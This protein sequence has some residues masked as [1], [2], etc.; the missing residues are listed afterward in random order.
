[1]L[2]SKHG[3]THRYNS[4]E[5]QR[6]AEELVVGRVFDAAPSASHAWN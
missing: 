4:S 1:M 6:M 5:N 3:R 2:L